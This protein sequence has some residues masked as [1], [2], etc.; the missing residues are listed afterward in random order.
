MKKMLMTGI[1]I[2]TV[3]CGFSAFAKK[4]LKLGDAAPEVSVQMINDKEYG[5]TFSLAEF[6]D[7]VIIV[8]F[9]AT[10]CP[11]CRQSIPHLSNLQEKYKDKVVV[12]GISGEE[13]TVVEKFFKAQP[14]MKYRVAIDNEDKT[15]GIYMIGFGVNGIPHAFIIKEGKILWHGH[16]ME[17]D[18]TLAKAVGNEK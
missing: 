4:E 7:K 8:E 9:W 17:M 5:K 3:L 2:A 10:W 15:A 13:K 14:E 18:E 6:K 16:P 1:V 11:P 12:I